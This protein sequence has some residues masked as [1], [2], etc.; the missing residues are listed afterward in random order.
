M[1]K[2]AT[3][4]YDSL[5]RLVGV[6]FPNGAQATYAYDDMGNRTTVVEVPP[7]TGT[8]STLPTV[9]ALPKKHCMDFMNN[10]MMVLL[11]DGQLIG[12]G[13]N[14]TG[15]LA[16]G[17]AS[18]TSSAQRVLFDPNTTIPPANATIVD[19]AFTNAS[20][21]V[22]YSNGWVYSAGDSSVGQLG[23]GD[24][25]SRLNLKR[26]EYFV[27]NNKSITKVWAACHTV[28][29]NGAG[30]AYFQDSNKNM[31]A[32]GGGGS[33]NLGNA[34]TPTASL[35]T[36]APITGVTTSPYVVEM[37]ISC[38]F[39]AFSA[40]MLMSDGTVL[41]A[42]Y[43]GQG[44]L[45][46]GTT[47]N[48]TGGFVNAKKTG[49]TNITNLVSISATAG[50]PN[51][52]S[53]LGVDSSGNVWTVGYNGSGQLGHGNLSDKNLFT[54]VA[55][56][57]NISKAE[58]GG[59]QYAY[60]YA[61]NTSGNVYTWGYNGQN[62]LFLNHSNAAYTPVQATYIPGT[63]SRFFFPREQQLGASS[64]LIAVTTTGKVVYAGTDVSQLG[65][66]NTVN[67]G[68]YKYI[69]MPISILNGSEVITDIFTHGTGLAQRFFALTDLG[70]L[71][72]SGSNL[73]SICTGG[74][75]SSMYKT[76]F[77]KIQFL[78]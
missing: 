61:I 8:P 36:P 28:N 65:L 78:P 4:Q 56:L 42:G 10:P 2:S 6:T 20:L 7:L 52:G 5:G 54:Q 40:Y 69:P 63:A 75:T 9:A 14:T 59:G 57:S 31:Y 74:E 17:I 35:S 48:I 19:W 62:N 21:Y 68:A 39:S 64:Q 23:H 38:W 47:T 71:Y 1:S 72:A 25:V 37:A 58:I 67:P 66:A 15:C 55:A 13:E 50:Y 16:N 12:W 45:A 49:S 41:V 53:A 33:G 18:T 29:M 11:S 51:G 60:C 44:Q 27:T 46:N 70:N 26:I 30:C 77:Y 32:C 34:S 43:N 76:A 24:T 3:Y 22:V 73:N